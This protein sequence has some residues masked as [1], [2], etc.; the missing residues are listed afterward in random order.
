MSIRKKDSARHKQ[1]IITE[2]FVEQTLSF[3]K[4]KIGIIIQKFINV[5]E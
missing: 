1:D 4:V 5:V 2:F 3:D